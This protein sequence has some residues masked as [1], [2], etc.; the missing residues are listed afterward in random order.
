MN[1]SQLPN[2]ITLV[3]LAL[4]PAFVLLLNDGDYTWA[5]AVFLIAG[6]SDGL[7]GFIAKR[8]NYQSRLGA[9]LDP[10]ADKI[11]LVSAFVMLSV[12]HH[13]PVWLVIVV[14]FRDLLIV[15]GYVLY[16]ST[17]GPVHMRP[18]WISK[19]NT[20]MQI[21]MIVIVLTQ[22]AIGM[23]YPNVIESLVY[24]VLVTTVAS[25]GHYLWTWGIMKDIEH[26]RASQRDE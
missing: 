14:V 21:A 1:V 11:L 25:G 7:D 18:S 6:V 13:V 9:I 4:A 20:F 26:V 16:T 24:A 17:Y 8:F 22:Q 10:V 3:R 23:S 2:L 19:L 5:L 15:G 12:L